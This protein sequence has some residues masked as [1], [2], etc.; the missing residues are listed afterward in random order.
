MNQKFSA[1]TT[2]SYSLPDENIRKKN[3]LFFFGTVKK[4]KLQASATN[5]ST[6]IRMCCYTQLK[7]N[8]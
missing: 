8:K 6:F 3:F 5:T 1:N 7:K 2:F 4:F